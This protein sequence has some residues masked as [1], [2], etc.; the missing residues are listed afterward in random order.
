MLAVLIQW[1]K[2]NI[3]CVQVLCWGR[4]TQRQI[5]IRQ[6]VEALHEENDTHY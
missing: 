5:R 3:C 2:L 4:G 1:Q 6:F